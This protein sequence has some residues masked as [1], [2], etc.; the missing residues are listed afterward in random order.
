MYSD[1]QIQSKF[2]GIM[3]EGY[4]PDAEMYDGIKI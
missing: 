3:Y 4:I 1:D 2:R